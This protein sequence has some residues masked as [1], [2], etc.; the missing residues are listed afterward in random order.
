MNNEIF[1]YLSS[2]SGDAKTTENCRIKEIAIEICR[3]C[4]LYEKEYAN[5]SNDVRNHIEQRVSEEFAKETNCW[6]SLQNVF[7]LGIP[8]PSGNE[9]DT[10]VDHDIIYKVNNLLNSRGSI[11]FLLKK[12][13]LHNFI[14]EE[15]AY[16][17]VGFTGF[18]NT[19]IMPIFKQDLIKN[20]M[21]ATQIE[22]ST[23]MAAL[24]FESTEKAGAYKNKELKV[25]DV[26][27]R[28]VLK[29][30]EGDIFV[31]DAEIQ[32]L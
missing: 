19:S 12:I 31:I 25:W 16:Q 7:E 6:F 10:Y 26:L 15:T 22:I 32:L 29:D 20:A 28:N 2:R 3:R 23:Y 27:P 9:N 11:I 17:F 4:S 21:P 1:E 14:F 13:L 30:A 8:G 24:G 5:S 18:E